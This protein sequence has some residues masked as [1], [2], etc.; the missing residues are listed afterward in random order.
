MSDQ[1][2][3]VDTPFKTVGDQFKTMAEAEEKIAPESVEAID[4]NVY[5]EA[6]SY[7]P[8]LMEAA[9]AEI[10][11]KEVLKKALQYIV[12]NWADV[13]ATYPVGG[14]CCL[15][16]LPASDG[17]NQLTAD[18]IK[19]NAYMKLLYKS[20]VDGLTY[21]FSHKAGPYIELLP[22]FIQK[23]CVFEVDDM[24]SPTCIKNFADNYAKVFNKLREFFGLQP[25]PRE[26]TLLKAA[27]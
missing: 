20:G 9:G 24:S 14:T 13:V 27:S 15:A 3:D 25:I 7:I 6:C 10:L 18:E 19:K 21:D 1:M 26:E 23:N 5:R 22:K 8:E 16:V 17:G 2:N 12:R 11:S 4:D